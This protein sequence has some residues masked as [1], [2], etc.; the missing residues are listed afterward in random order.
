MRKA[1][2][3]TKR[4]RKC[5]QTVFFV[6]LSGIYVFYS[7][8]ITSQELSKEFKRKYKNAVKSY[9]KE[10][11]NEA[12]V[13]FKDISDFYPL[14][15]DANVY[16]ANI[17]LDQKKEFDVAAKIYE[18]IIPEIGEQ[19][20]ILKN[21]FKNK[22]EEKEYKRLRNL[23]KNCE[24]SLKICRDTKLDQHKQKEKELERKRQVEEEKLKHE[25]EQ[26]PQK[27]EYPQVDDKS[28]YLPEYK[29]DVSE[30]D[31]VTSFLFAEGSTNNQKE[32]YIQKYVKEKYEDQ[33]ESDQFSKF[34][35]EKIIE[36]N[37]YWLDKVKFKQYE[38]F[39]K[40]K[41]K[42]SYFRAKQEQYNDILRKKMKIENQI[43]I[44]NNEING[45]EQQ[46]SILD[47]DLNGLTYI[48]DNM[49]QE[50]LKSKLATIPKSIVLVGR[51]Q[52]IE[53]YDKEAMGKYLMNKMN[54]KAIESINGYRILTE[55]FIEDT[56]IRELYEISYEGIAQT[57][58]KYYKEVKQIFKG[59][60]GETEQGVYKI[61]RIEVF[62]FS[63][64]D[65]ELQTAQEREKSRNDP[66][67]DYDIY[68]VKS[69]NTS[70]LVNERN[71]K[72]SNLTGDHQFKTEERQFVKW[73]SDFSNRL[74][75]NYNG[76]IIEAVS[77]FKH[78]QFNYEKKIGSMHA[79][80]ESIK[81]E[82]M[83][84]KQELLDLNRQLN[85]FKTSSIQNLLNE[86]NEAQ[87]IYKNHYMK[88]YQFEN[89]L[90]I[91]GSDHLDVSIGEGF[92]ELVKDCYHS[93]GESLS[94]KYNKTTIYKEITNED[95]F[96][97]LVETTVDYNS[98]VDSLRILTLNM[99]KHGRENFLAL[100]LAFQIRWECV[101]TFKDSVN[102]G[103][104]STPKEIEEPVT[105]N[106]DYYSTSTDETSPG[107]KWKAYINNPT[108]QIRFNPNSHP[109]WR[110]PSIK[111]LSR[112]I[113]DPDNKE[114]LI[115]SIFG[116]NI[117]PEDVLS[118]V[119]I[120]NSQSRDI[121]NR[122]VIDAIRLF[123]DFNTENIKVTDGS[124]VHIILTK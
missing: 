76:K 7:P 52:L 46:I 66:Y 44:V 109:G 13:E 84:K 5:I 113:S 60:S 120:T 91:L 34:D 65:E 110:I 94:K 50:E 83:G 82:S 102:Q 117:W 88:R 41:E 38:W 43:H 105:E 25:Y 1:K 100:N 6:L 23:K 93:I 29:Y 58:N 75:S 10:Q 21:K 111:A 74:N 107:L 9:N 69:N 119:F 62:P 122:K 64:V 45:L 108:S 32:E 87:S 99:Y 104:A 20:E 73:L 15:V 39:E 53:G 61:F 42:E 98:I 77:Q 55:T 85:S 14:H 92:E 97:R 19:I 12:L 112:I 51:A 31:F 28:D 89:H 80:V 115:E 114:K 17:Y 26:W 11:Y 22:K 35:Y 121:N 67:I 79:Q 8:S 36:I 103:M 18:R 56:N 49:L 81:N 78:K 116:S 96:Y 68:C 24:N 101:N 47:D 2:I 106:P 40:L 95:E 123:K 72:E 54:N 63:K 57:K 124:K 16:L 27:E 48:K 37:N 70:I 59:E 118:V 71:Q 30:D 90:A 3:N 33:I 86:Y 4:S